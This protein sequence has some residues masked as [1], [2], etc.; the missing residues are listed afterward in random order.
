VFGMSGRALSASSPGPPANGGRRGSCCWSETGN[1]GR[2]SSARGLGVGSGQ[3]ARAATPPC[4]AL[5]PSV[6]SFVRSRRAQRNMP[7]LATHTSLSRLLTIS[8][9]RLAVHACSLGKIFHMRYSEF[10]IF[11]VDRSTGSAACTGWRSGLSLSGSW[12]KGKASTD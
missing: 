4:R 12:A 2:Q 5:R 1:A 9:L 10:Q 8:A 3:P 7:A 6:H 11:G